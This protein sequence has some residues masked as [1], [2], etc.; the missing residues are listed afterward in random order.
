[1]IENRGKTGFEGKKSEVI[2]NEILKVLHKIDYRL[3]WI[4]DELKRANR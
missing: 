1:M 3:E 4:Q 2:L